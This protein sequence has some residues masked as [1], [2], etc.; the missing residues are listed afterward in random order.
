[1]P[2]INLRGASLR[3]E[4]LGADGPWVALSP[5]GRRD[6]AAMLPI[7]TGV[8]DAGYRVLVHDRRNCG[9]SSVVLGDAG[10]D[11]EYGIW[12]ED[13]QALLRELD[14]LPAVIGGG[15]SGCRMAIAHAQRYPASVRALLLWKVT[16]GAFAAGRLAHKYYGEYIEAAQRGGMPAVMTTP[17]FA[18]CLAAQVDGGA[19]DRARMLAIDPAAF[20]A[21]FARWHQGFLDDAQLPVLGATAEQ[22]RALD[23]P[24]LVI[25]GD[26]NTHPRTAGEALARLLPRGEVEVMFPEHHDVDVVDEASWSARDS[27]IAERFVAFLKRLAR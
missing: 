19:A 16:G 8:A 22:L 1:M 18:E 15:S 17:H 25:P 10:G 26:D 11:T 5:G 7:A 14:A 3:Y 12:A 21:S 27:E 2:M 23:M 24:A 9:A 13:Q 4:V 6:L 20:I